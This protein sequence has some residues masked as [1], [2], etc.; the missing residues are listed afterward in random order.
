[1]SHKRATTL[2]TY[3]CFYPCHSGI[4][5]KVKALNK[6]DAIDKADAKLSRFSEDKFDEA[7]IENCYGMVEAC[8]TVDE[9]KP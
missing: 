5:V 6:Q 2:K 4:W 7:I 9:V 3:E 8:D 1:M